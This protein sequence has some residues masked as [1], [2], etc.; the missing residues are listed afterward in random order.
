MK[1]AAARSKAHDHNNSKR[2]VRTSLAFARASTWARP[3]EEEVFDTSFNVPFPTKKYGICIRQCFWL[4]AHPLI[5]TALPAEIPKYPARL[6]CAESR[7][8][9]F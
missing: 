5:I 2:P 1:A 8:A 4:L 7:L 6:R 3:F 9:Y